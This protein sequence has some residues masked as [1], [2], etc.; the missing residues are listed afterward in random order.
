MLL[1][2]VSHPSQIEQIQRLQQQNLPQNI[3]P[4]EYQEQGFVTCEHTLGLLSQLNH[5]YPHVIAVDDDHLAGYALVMLASE[6]NA[7]EVLIPMFDRIDTLRW[8]DQPIN[9][10]TYFTMGQVC[11]DKQYRGQGLFYKL[12]DHM[13]EVMSPHFQL[14][15]TE[16]SSHNK[17]SLRA[18]ANQGFQIIEK[19]NSPDGHPWEIIG[20]D[21]S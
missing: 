1:T 6:R 20:W 21:W 18:H 4:Q 5:P 15:I 19:Y 8:E 2:T 14:C 10:I 11:I 13:K 12:Y 16:V 9:K 7:L 17:R 3:S